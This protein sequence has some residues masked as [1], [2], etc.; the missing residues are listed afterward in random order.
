VF[1]VRSLIFL[2]LA[3]SY[4]CACR[5]AARF[6]LACSGLENN[7]DKYQSNAIQDTAYRRKLQSNLQN[8]FLREKCIYAN[9]LS[10]DLHLL[11]SDTQSAKK[12]FYQ[13]I[14]AQPSNDYA[15]YAL[16]TIF[17]QEKQY[18]SALDYYRYAA[19]LKSQGKEVIIEDTELSSQINGEPSYQLNY[20]TKYSEIIFADAVASFYGGYLTDAEN[21]LNY[22]I[23]SEKHRHEAYY[24][25]GLISQIKGDMAKACEYMNQA[26]LEGHA[27]APKFWRD[28]CDK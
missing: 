4:L 3:C 12:K 25:L 19:K 7:F 24:Y 5:D 6:P 18:D 8:L 1:S 11:S 20:K 22:S 17:F 15:A 2:L 28:N 9:L 13:L 27:L 21:R 16:G 23:G 10:A 26:S 14:Q